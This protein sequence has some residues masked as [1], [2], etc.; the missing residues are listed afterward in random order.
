[1]LYFLSTPTNPTILLLILAPL[2][3]C[4]IDCYGLRLRY[5]EMYAGLPSKVQFVVQYVPYDLSLKDVN[6]SFYYS[7]QLQTYVSANL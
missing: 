4:Y 2:I 3:N 6:R 1:M 5:F 7:S